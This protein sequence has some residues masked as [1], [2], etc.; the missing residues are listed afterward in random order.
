MFGGPY[1]NLAATRAMRAQANMLRIPPQNVFCNGDLVA[2]CAEPEQTVEQI[3]DWGISVVMG[4]CEE[5]LA[6]QAADCGCGFESGSACALLSD[7]WYDFARR[8]VSD[9]SRRWMQR[10][11]RAIRLQVKDRHILLTHGAPSAINRFVFASTAAAEKTAEFTATA[12]DIIVGGHSGIP[13]GER[14]GDKFWLNTGVIGMPAND[15]SRDGW[16]LLLE[17]DGSALRATWKR[18]AYDWRQ[19]QRAMTE[20]GLD[21]GYA[22]ALRT[23][24]WPSMDVLPATER[25]QCGKRLSLDDLLV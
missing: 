20:A 17:A 3:R 21:N 18:L 22:R 19:S 16:Y 15:G 13:F 2:Y 9:D 25:A 5:S 14:L 4:N 10:L 1:S 8:R 7:H 6:E 24:L 23:G 12:A 11:P